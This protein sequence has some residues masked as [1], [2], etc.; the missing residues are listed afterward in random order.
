MV[1]ANHCIWKQLA[2]ARKEA[3]QLAAM[4]EDW[5]NQNYRLLSSITD[6]SRDV[7][8]SPSAFRDSQ[9]GHVDAPAGA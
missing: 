7:T 4:D 9:L 1:S 5:Q 2:K 8:D 3:G 6:L